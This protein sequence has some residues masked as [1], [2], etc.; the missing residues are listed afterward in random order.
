MDANTNVKRWHDWGSL[1]LG[2]WMFISPWVMLYP[3]DVPN[4]TWN[5]YV[6]GAAIVIFSA[7][8]VY[9]PKIWEEGVNI[10]LGIW[11]LLSPWALGF[12]GYRDITV[13]SVIVGL[14]VI[15]LSA[16]AMM[17]DKQFERWLHE[18]HVTH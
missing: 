14:L 2:A 4:A 6:I 9:M 15:A 8:A 13:N 3:V 11:L 12:A 7:I 18:R 10:V 1:L 5:A 16:W 17:R